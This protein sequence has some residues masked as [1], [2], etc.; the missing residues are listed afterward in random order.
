MKRLLLL[1]LGLLL[2]ACGGTS[3]ASMKATTQMGFNDANA[4]KKLDAEVDKPLPDM[5][6]ESSLAL[7]TDPVAMC[8]KPDVD[9]QVRSEA[10]S[11][12]EK[13]KTALQDAGITVQ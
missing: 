8:K 9:A 3:T 11:Q 4:L 12:L 6:K 1:V 2:P 10:S 5:W 13:A 7:I